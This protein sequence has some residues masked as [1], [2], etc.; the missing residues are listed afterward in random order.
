ME[1]TVWIFGY[2]SPATSPF[3]VCVRPT[4]AKRVRSRVGTF[5]APRRDRDQPFA[6]SRP[7]D[8]HTFSAR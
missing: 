3:A 1:Q 4:R 8:A 6:I 2:R 7:P 5:A